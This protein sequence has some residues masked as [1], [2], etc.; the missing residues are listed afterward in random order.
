MTREKKGIQCMEHELGS[1]TGRDL[2]QNTFPPES[3]HYQ[4]SP[5][6]L[7]QGS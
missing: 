2:A 1:L 5:G 4:P 7:E 6:P 3:L